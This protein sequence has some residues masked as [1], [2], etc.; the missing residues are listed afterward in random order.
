MGELIKR[1]RGG[2]GRGKREMS[3]WPWWQQG[4]RQTGGCGL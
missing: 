2:K 4:W 1:G 3:K